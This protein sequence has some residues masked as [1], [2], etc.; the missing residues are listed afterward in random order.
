MKEERT[1]DEVSASPP[2]IPREQLGLVENLS[3][4]QREIVSTLFFL[5]VLTHVKSHWNVCS[6][7]THSQ[8]Q[9]P[10]YPPLTSNQCT[11]M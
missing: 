11:C 1:E 4:R 6:L 8:Y 9:K 10:F 2:V 7:Y 3:L 5:Q